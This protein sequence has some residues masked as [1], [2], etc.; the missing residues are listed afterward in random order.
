VLADI[1]ADILDEHAIPESDRETWRQ[2][3]FQRARYILAPRL[4]QLK[5]AAAV[6]GA[7]GELDEAGLRALLSDEPL[8]LR[9][10]SKRSSGTWGPGDYDVIDGS[11]SRPLSR[12]ASASSPPRCRRMCHSR[13]PS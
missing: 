9:H 3:A 10:A 5:R 8:V 4:D 12:S 2:S 11:R 6:L 7:Q 1:L 13:L